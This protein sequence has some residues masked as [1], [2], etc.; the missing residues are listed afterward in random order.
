[1]TTLMKLLRGYKEG[2]QVKISFYRLDPSSKR[3]I[4]YNNEQPCEDIEVVVRDWDNHKYIAHIPF[5]ESLQEYVL[6]FAKL[7]GMNGQPFDGEIR[8]VTARIDKSIEHFQLRGR[9]FHRA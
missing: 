3:L 1:M 6:P 9:E 4:I 8:T 2:R 5:L 7:F